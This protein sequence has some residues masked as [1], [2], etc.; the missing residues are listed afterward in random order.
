VAV[1]MATASGIADPSTCAPATMSTR[2]Q[3]L[4]LR[5]LCLMPTSCEVHIPSTNVASS[6]VAS[7]ATSVCGGGVGSRTSAER[8][9]PPA[10]VLVTSPSQNRSVDFRHHK[11]IQSAMQDWSPTRLLGSSK[12]LTK[13]TRQQSWSGHP[14]GWQYQL[15]RLTWPPRLLPGPPPAAPSP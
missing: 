14:K 7:T 12:K 11:V 2:N 9:S 13:L 3:F 10:G 6:S 8:S 1:S 4:R 15:S 5:P